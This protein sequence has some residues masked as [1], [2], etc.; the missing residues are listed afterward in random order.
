[1]QGNF[2]TAIANLVTNLTSADKTNIKNAIFENSFLAS[3]ITDF[4]D[5]R[6]DVRNGSLQPIVGR[7]TDL[8]TGLKATTDEQSC[9][10]NTGTLTTNYKTKKW[11]IGEYNERFPL[12]LKNVTEDF[13][14]FWNLYR[15]RLENPL[16]SPD[17]QTYVDF[18]LAKVEDKLNPALWRISYLGDTSAT[19]ATAN[20]IN[21]N[22]GFFVQAQAGSGEK[23][24]IT[25]ATPTGQELYGYMKQAY[26]WAIMQEWFNEEEFVWDVPRAVAGAIVK[27]LNDA[28]DQSIYNCTC[29]DPHQ[30]VGRRFFTMD[31]LHIFGIPVRVH[32]EIDHSKTAVGDTDK[33]EILL[34]RKG[35]TLIGT[36]NQ[37]ALKDFDIFYDQ[38]DRTV[39]I[40]AMIYAGSMLLTDEYVYI[41]T[42]IA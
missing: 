17:Y 1:M 14:V 6:M 37:E 30:I 41:S 33:F 27:M 18:L 8:Y 5:L 31:T 42:K 4:H 39:Y 32:S 35:D 3:D 34:T 16:T 13:L 12:C 15:Q 11:S 25:Q 2:T 20:L 7:Q 9:S 24:K 21:N 28:N 10:M 36:N 40:D 29:I 38:K 19:G 22:N 26:D 23:I